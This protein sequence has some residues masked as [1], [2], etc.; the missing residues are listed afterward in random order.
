MQTVI[1]NSEQR[2]TSVQKKITRRKT[3]YILF[4]RL[5]LHFYDNVFLTVHHELT[6]LVH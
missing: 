3:T 4:Q 5:W 2:T 1:L 6:I